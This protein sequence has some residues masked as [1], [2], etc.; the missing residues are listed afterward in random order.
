MPDDRGLDLLLRYLHL[1]TPR[2]QGRRVLGAPADDLLGRPILPL[3]Q[4]LD[5]PQGAKVVPQP[6]PRR[7]SLDVVARYATFVGL[8]VE[9]ARL[10]HTSSKDCIPLALAFRQPAAR[11]PP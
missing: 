4:R 3:N 7:P 2:A 8:T 6:A 9:L 11:R 1:M 5:E 10:P